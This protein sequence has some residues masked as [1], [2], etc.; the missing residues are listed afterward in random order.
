M[1][2]PD[3]HSFPPVSHAEWLDKVRADLKGREPASLQWSPEPG[4]RL[5]ALYPARSTDE[6]ALN[7]TRWLS[8]PAQV[9][10]R[11]WRILQGTNQPSA[12]LE[13]LSTQPDHG[14]DGIVL[15]LDH[16]PTAAEL[17]DLAAHAAKQKVWLRMHFPGASVQQM[18][19]LTEWAKDKDL[20]AHFFSYNLDPFRPLIT[21]GGFAGTQSDAFGNLKAYAAF[22][23]QHP[24]AGKCTLS[25]APLHE[26]GAS[27]VQQIAFQLSMLS[28]VLSWLEEN[29]GTVPA[30][31]NCLCLDTAVGAAFF[32]EVAKLRTLRYLAGR[33]ASRYGFEGRIH[34]HSQGSRREQSSLD[35]NVNMLRA[36]TQAMS[37]ITGG[38]D[39]LSLPP[40]N[41]AFEPNEPF[42]LR[43]AK[44]I[45]LLL[46]HESHLG[47]VHDPAAGA[48]YIESLSAELARL[49]WELFLETEAEGGFTAA[50]LSG[51]IQKRVKENASREESE[52][53]TRKRSR[54]GVN[55]FAP[56]DPA[57]LAKPVAPLP[58]TGKVLAE[59]LPPQRPAQTY[60]ALRARAAALF[61]QKPCRIL[62][63]RFGDP[64]M[65]QARAGFARQL[66]EL[67]GL[68][69]N[70]ALANELNETEWNTA[71][72]IVLCSSDAEYAGFASA[73][74]YPIPPQTWLLIAG[75]P[76]NAEAFSRQ[77]DFVIAAKMEVPAFFETFFNR[78]E[79]AK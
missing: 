79:A 30:F 33:I 2:E 69:C 64:V 55:Q 29:N 77:P 8:S 9:N 51:W 1:A 54:V 3:F 57:P 68:K 22:A 52:L 32:P 61:Q 76:E 42:G 15:S 16:T 34:L 35:F 66:F 14:L 44:N 74:P 39:S 78:W 28:D 27:L 20:P 63:L 21:H 37:A 59:A 56:Q 70:T 5:E 50:F 45:Q 73:M 43:I 58:F 19:D 38:C 17:Q 36:T 53:A 12:L 65:S 6:L 13:L 25:S 67:A 26:A 46:R 23:Q 49:S 24:W 72:V 7:I 31:L 75:R 18:E 10:R 47:R 62:L 48:G 41:Q 71:Q 40:Y 60:E 4:L 11:N